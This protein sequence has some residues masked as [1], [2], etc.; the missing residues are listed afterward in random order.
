MPKKKVKEIIGDSTGKEAAQKIV[1]WLKKNNNY[2]PYY[3]I[4]P[5]CGK[6][7]KQELEIERMRA[8]NCSDG[9]KNFK[10]RRI[11]HREMQ[12]KIKEVEQMSNRFLLESSDYDLKYEMRIADLTRVDKTKEDFFND[13]EGC[14]NYNEFLEYLYDNNAFLTKDEAEKILNEQDRQIKET[15]DISYAFH[16]QQQDCRK[17]VLKIREEK[18]EIEFQLNALRKWY[19]CRDCSFNSREMEYLES[20]RK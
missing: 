5:R 18:R 12:E 6:T 19:T 15:K 3:F 1:E 10:Q 16:K 20:L 2:E 17:E 13:E 11:F 8:L 9:P 7:F 14:Y 4:P